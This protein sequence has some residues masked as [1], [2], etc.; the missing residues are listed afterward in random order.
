MRILI[1]GTTGQLG[2]ELQRSLAPFGEILAP[3]RTALDLSR[4]EQVESWLD[5]A[6]PDLVVNPAAYTA[7]DKAE[8]EKSLAFAVNHHTPAALARW[9]AKSRVPLIHFSTDY[10]F[11][12]TGSEPFVESSSTGPVNVYGTSKRDGEQ[13]VRDSGCTHYIFRTSWV[14]AARGQNFLNT[15][16]RLADSRP[17]IRVVDDQIGAPTPARLLADLTAQV[18]G[19]MRVRPAK[20]A[21]TCGTYHV[22]TSGQT[23][24]HGFATEIMRL[25][26]AVTGLPA[27]VVTAIP[28][29]EY[30][31]P[32][33]RP[34]NSRLDCSRFQETFGLLLPD[35]R[36][37]LGTTISDRLLR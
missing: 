6:K 8:V 27:P 19:A 3:A 30:P 2:W 36:D 29:S 14:Y 21:E 4:P 10:V 34:M 24:W 35:W 17:E 31:T 7:V 11:P 16:L 1:T 37:G 32:A 5:S 13:A 26:S 18:I 20:I 33:S 25:R 22:T 12:G 15:M 9:C 28:T 23:S